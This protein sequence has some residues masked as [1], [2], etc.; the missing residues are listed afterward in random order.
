MTAAILANVL[1]SIANYDY[2]RPKLI[3]LTFRARTPQGYTEGPISGTYAQGQIIKPRII[4]YYD[5]DNSAT[6]T[7]S[8]FDELLSIPGSFEIRNV[9]RFSLTIKPRGATYVYRTGVPAANTAPTNWIGQR[10]NQNLGWLQAT[11]PGDS[12]SSQAQLLI[13]PLKM[14]IFYPPPSATYGLVPMLYDVDA[15]FYWQTK[16][17]QTL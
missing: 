1:L 8:S 16:D 2:W 11:S 17:I 9:M 10:L 6:A 15:C 14:F 5:A 7:P 4:C 13:A 3:K 12:T